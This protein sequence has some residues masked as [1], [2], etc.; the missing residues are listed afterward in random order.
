M[1]VLN[2]EEGHRDNDAIARKALEAVGGRLW[3]TQVVLTDNLGVVAAVCLQSGTT[4][5]YRMPCCI[6][7][8]LKCI[9]KDGL[10]YKNI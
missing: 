1:G 8:C 5:G 2:E 3:P 6:Q 9:R 4:D 7:S 10:L